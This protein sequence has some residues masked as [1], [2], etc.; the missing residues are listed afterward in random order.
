MKLPFE[1]IRNVIAAYIDVSD[2]EWNI[3]ASNFQ[4]KKFKKNELL[5]Q[6]GA[7]CKELYFVN[8]GLLR[9]FFVDKKGEEHTFHFS[10]ENAFSTD[11]ESFL[12][13][14][15]SNYSIQ[16]LENTEVVSISFETLEAG[17][18]N[19]RDGEKLGRR[20]A[21]DYFFLFGNK[22]R[23]FYTESPMERYHNMDLVF[24]GILQRV[25]QHFIASYLNIS[26]VHL[27]RLKNS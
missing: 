9:V 17:Y 5:L 16:A 2:E 21:E 27:S 25:P 7:I 26:S 14:A 4:L 11:Y 8:S 13:K 22:I 24:P 20:L 12:K 23:S 18:R 1:K 15:A 6:A 10:L 3:Y 19:L